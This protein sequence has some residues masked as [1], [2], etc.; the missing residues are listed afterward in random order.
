MQLCFLGVTSAIKNRRNSNIHNSQSQGWVLDFRARVKIAESCPK[1]LYNL[2]YVICTI[3]GLEKRHI[4][5][6]F[7]HVTS[8]KAPTFYTCNTKILLAV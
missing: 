8:K 6:I 4:A 5:L 7:V 2:W 3:Y 1:T